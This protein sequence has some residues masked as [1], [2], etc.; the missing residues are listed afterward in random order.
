LERGE[1]RLSLCERERRQIDAP[2]GMP[3]RRRALELAGLLIKHAQACS[4][5]AGKREAPRRRPGAPAAGRE[6]GPEEMGTVARG[7]H[8]DHPVLIVR[9]VSHVGALR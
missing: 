2:Q 4:E 5:L 1:R 7:D 3:V 9:S 8:R 6:R